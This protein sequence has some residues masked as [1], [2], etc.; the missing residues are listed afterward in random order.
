MADQDRETRKFHLHLVSD[1]TGETIHALARACL[2]QFEDVEA[3]E[4]VWS[5]VR[6]PRQLDKVLAGI[7]ASPGVVLFTLVDLKLR[8]G[9]EAG[10]RKAGIPCIPVLDPVL[11]ALGNYLKA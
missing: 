2:V 1:A 10:C 3:I 7:T 4:H 8:D 11:A 5:M 6:S 9:L